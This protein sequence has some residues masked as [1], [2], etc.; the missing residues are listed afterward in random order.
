LRAHRYAVSQRL[1]AALLLL[2]CTLFVLLHQSL[3]SLIPMSAA[4][5]EL[6]FGIITAASK[7]FRDAYAQ[8]QAPTAW[9]TSAS[10]R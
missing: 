3:L 10:S 4:V 5:K 7:R 2:L 8:M 9:E 1:F 6:L